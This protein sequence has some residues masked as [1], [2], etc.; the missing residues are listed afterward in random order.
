MRIE[1]ATHASD[2][3]TSIRPS[4]RAWLNWYCVKWM[5]TKNRKFPKY[6][7]TQNI[8]CNHS[9]IWIMCHRVMSSNDADRMANSVDPDQ[10]APLGAVWSGSAQFAQTCLSE[11]LGTLRYSN[12]LSQT[13][14]LTASLHVDLI[15][16]TE[17]HKQVKT[18]SLICTFVVRIRHKQ[19]FSS[20]GSYAPREHLDQLAHPHSLI[21]LHFPHAE[22]FGP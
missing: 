16:N 13:R 8:C 15:D 10:T 7:D 17:K 12:K 19:V 2:R 3:A 6:S 11:N 1:P 21:S 20:C 4:Y 18:G 5:S 14:Q 22:V 9:K